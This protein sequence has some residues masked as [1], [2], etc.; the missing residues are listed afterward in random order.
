MFWHFSVQ[1]KFCACSKLFSRMGWLYHPHTKA[2][3]SLAPQHFVHVLNRSLLVS[4]V[5]G[6]QLRR[7][8]RLVIS[9]SAVL[10]QLRKNSWPYA[11][12]CSCPSFTSKQSSPN[13]TGPFLSLICAF[14]IVSV[15][16]QQYSTERVLSPWTRNF[17]YSLGFCLPPKINCDLISGWFSFS[18]PVQVSR[19]VVAGD[20]RLDI[21]N[22]MSS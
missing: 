15:P 6:D 7:C 18:C 11:S 1:I 21:G 9:S 12:P 17:L 3:F 5:E 2:S 20:Q 19:T 13:P 14:P 10:L 4:L 22:C 8:S 16:M